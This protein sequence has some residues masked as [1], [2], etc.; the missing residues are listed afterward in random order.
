RSTRIFLTDMGREA[1]V[2]IEKQW[3]EL[4]EEILTEL[5]ETERLVLFDLLTKLKHF[6]F[7]TDPDE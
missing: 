5:T 6:Y 3:H 4:E 7:G 1:R 2:A